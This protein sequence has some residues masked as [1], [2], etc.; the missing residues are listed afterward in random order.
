MRPSLVVLACALASG[1]SLSAGPFGDSCGAEPPGNCPE[2]HCGVSCYGDAYEC[3]DGSWQLVSYCDA[4]I[5]GAYTIP[6]RWTWHQVVEPACNVTQGRLDVDLRADPWVSDGGDPQYATFTS[7][8][9]TL[10]IDSSEGFPT[11][12]CRDEVDLTFTDS[13][14]AAGVETPIAGTYHV[15]AEDP[16]HDLTGWFTAVTPDGCELTGTVTGMFD[17]DF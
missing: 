7:A 6:G 12:G 14:L 11:G 10:V 9:P 15:E 13:W 8:D 1:C 4:C 17:P 3:I 16:E 2:D 5:D